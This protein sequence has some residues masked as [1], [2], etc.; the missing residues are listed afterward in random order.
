MNIATLKSIGIRKSL[1]MIC[2]VI[3]FGMVLAFFPVR[4]YAGNENSTSKIS[5]GHIISI[6]EEYLNERNRLLV[7]SNP[8][9]NPNLQN[10]PMLKKSEMNEKIS[11]RQQGD[12][13]KIRDITKKVEDQGVRYWDRFETNVEIESITEA[14]DQTVVRIFEYTRLYFI[15]GWGVEYS[16]FNTERDF[17]FIREGNKW[18]ISD[19][20]IVDPGTMPPPN[21]PSV[22]PKA[23]DESEIKP[24]I[25]QMNSTE[26]EN[27]SDEDTRGITGGGWF[28]QQA[29]ID[30][31]RRY[32]DNNN[33]TDEW[34]WQ[35]YNGFPGNDCQNFVSQALHYAGWGLVT[36]GQS[37]DK[38]WYH[39]YKTTWTNSWVNVMRF[40]NHVSLYGGQRGHFT[41]NYDS[42]RVGDV[43]QLDTDINGDLNHSMIVSYDA[44]FYSTTLLH[45]IATIA[46]IFLLQIF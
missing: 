23:L 43:V 33:D 6:A 19:V 20:K 1:M 17:T 2:G 24:S 28:N 8:D 7:S 5:E 3:I 34:N 16:S 9:S 21:E 32:T 39:L 25:I 41:S 13:N 18:I 35:W 15:Q 45:T 27:T 31:C 26:I 10:V 42:L 38:L 22:E 44:G 29:V 37:G 36:T 40:R 4:V 11:E 30:Y 46:T 12:M 14:A